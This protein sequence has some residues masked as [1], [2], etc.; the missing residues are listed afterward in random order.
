MTAGIGQ[1]MS[2][3]SRS[4]PCDQTLQNDSVSSAKPL[5]DEVEGVL[6]TSERVIEHSAEMGAGSLST[7][8]MK[9]P[10]YTIGEVSEMLD[11]PPYV[12]MYWQKEF[13][14]LKPTRTRAWRRLFYYQGIE[15]LKFIDKIFCE[16]HLGIEDM[17]QRLK[18]M[19]RAKSSKKKD[20]GRIPMKEIYGDS[21]HSSGKA[22]FQMGRS[23]GNTGCRF[24]DAELFGKGIR[25]VQ[26]LQNQGKTP[27]LPQV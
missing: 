24:M 13:D 16:E 27:S 4:A 20:R 9:K 14:I 12:L 26:T 17:K 6:Q 19:R 11:V 18:E 5:F 21:K 25:R 2:E 22:I 7:P 23:F 10:Y 8:T 1:D 3:L 15:R